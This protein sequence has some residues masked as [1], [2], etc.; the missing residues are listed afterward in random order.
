MDAAC[1]VVLKYGM[2]RDFNKWLASLGDKAPVRTL[3]ELRAW[4][5]AHQKAGAI[6]Y[7][8]ARLDIAD[9]MD[10]AADRAR[11]MADREKDLRLSATEGIDAVMKSEQL[12][13]L[14]FPVYAGSA[15]AAK[16]GYP[17]VVVPFGLAMNPLKPPLPEGFAQ[18][19]SPMAVGF[20]GMAC[21]EPRLIEL[22]Y[23]FEQATKKR[24]PPP[25]FP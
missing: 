19:P 21:S 17:T 13:A 14:L 7:A 8:Q 16:P 12:D 22:A 10:L 23:A 18:K 9:E 5:V 25:M 1:S 24:I 6:K 11:Y 2:K 3:T 15:I 20:T 4:N